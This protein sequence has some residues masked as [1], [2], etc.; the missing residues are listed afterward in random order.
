MTRYEMA[1]L[2]EWAGTLQTRKRLQKVV[3]LLQAAGC[4]IEAD[5]TL[6]HYGP[7]SQETARLSDEMV[8]IDLLQE[9]SEQN[10]VGLQYSYQLSQQAKTGIAEFEK[11]A[12]GKELAEQLAP[13]EKKASELLTTD[14]WLLEV[15]A[16]LVYFR[17][18]GHDWAECVEKTQQF[19]NLDI[20]DKRFISKVEQLARQF[21]A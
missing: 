16:T 8:R 11:T 3:F 15:A 17:K 18:Q 9:S 14:L 12:K 2:V 19:K 21:T 4:P 10:R 13:Y 5:Y 7:Y 1:K 6:H 20:A